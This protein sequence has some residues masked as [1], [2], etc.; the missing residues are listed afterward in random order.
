MADPAEIARW[1][2]NQA[3]ALREVNAT[4][5]AAQAGSTG[6]ERDTAARRAFAAEQEA[7]AA[8][9]QV[10]REVSASAQAVIDAGDAELEARAL[11]A[12]GRTAEAEDKREYAI[13]LRAHAEA[14]QTR[15]AAAAEA[16]Q[17]ADATAKVEADQVV[18]L[19]ARLT[20]VNERARLAHEAAEALDTRAD[21]YKAAVPLDAE[22]DRLEALA[23]R[24]RAEGD[25]IVLPDVERDASAARQA[26]EA[27]VTKAEAVVV[28]RA[29]VIDVLGA[30]Q[31]AAEPTS[32]GEPVADAGTDPDPVLGDVVV[33][34]TD[35]DPA[36]AVDPGTMGDEDDDDGLEPE[37]ETDAMEP[38]VATTSPELEPSWSAPDVAFAD[39]GGLSGV[40]PDSDDGSE[41]DG[42]QV[43]ADAPAVDDAFG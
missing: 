39:D 31:G 36:P 25:D 30:T 5:Y 2:D 1:T 13:G 23:A 32:V 7:N 42:L 12:A 26:A 41:D 6:V 4:R 9:Q 19:E 24:L 27:A 18:A 17:A 40:E 3:D 28:D 14:A 33:A 29:V 43:E 37:T 34:T 10:K 21:L 20:E 8:R 35:G 38:E 22:A 16:A 15:V 11:D